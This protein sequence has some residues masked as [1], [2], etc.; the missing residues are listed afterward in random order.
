MQSRNAGHVVLQSERGR[1]VVGI[2][3]NGDEPLERVLYPGIPERSAV[4]RAASRTP[5][6]IEF[7]EERL[8]GPFRLRNRRKIVGAPDDIRRRQGPKVVPNPEGRRQDER[9]E[10]EVNESEVLHLVALSS[11]LLALD[12][13]VVGSSQ[14][15]LRQT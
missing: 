13:E 1:G 2:Y 3:A 4:E 11:R 8:V 6:G 14:A 15:K 9:P 5:C 7:D 12:G 10:E